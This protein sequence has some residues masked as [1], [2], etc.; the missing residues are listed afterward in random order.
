MVEGIEDGRFAV[1]TK[2]H[3]SLFDGVS[4]LR[5]HAELAAGSLRTG[6][7]E[8]SSGNAIGAVIASLATDVEDP[9]DRM[10]AIRESVQS[11]KRVM[12]ELSP[13]QI[14][15]LSAF[16]VSQL[17]MSPIPGL[18]RARRSSSQHH[19]D[20]QCRSARLRNNR[21]PPNRSQPATSHSSR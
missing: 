15:L 10:M 20:Q 9:L 19:A 12:D 11:A 6:D 16:N 13:L 14:M 1:Y 8:H 3:H 18:D 4:A 5:G 7:P 21:L 2:I 17:A